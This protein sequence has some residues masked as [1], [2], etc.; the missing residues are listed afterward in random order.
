MKSQQPTAHNTLRVS[1]GNY[2]DEIS[3]PDTLPISVRQV[4]RGAVFSYLN[5]TIT[6]QTSTRELEEVRKSGLQ[7]VEIVDPMEGNYLLAILV[8]IPDNPA[9][10]RQFIYLDK[11]YQG[12][13]SLPIQEA[14]PA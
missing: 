7:W 2:W 4:L 14:E 11:L 10:H 12:G 9:T 6:P 8:F 5:K 3:H 13:R 1:V